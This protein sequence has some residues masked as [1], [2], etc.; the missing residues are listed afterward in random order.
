MKNLFQFVSAVF[1]GK[2]ARIFVVTNLLLLLIFTNWHEVS[3][4][5]SH[6]NQIGCRPTASGIDFSSYGLSGGSGEA[7][8]YTFYAVLFLPSVIDTETILSLLKGV[9]PAWCR[10]TFDILY[11][12]IFTVFN[13]FHWLLLG[14]MIEILHT[15]FL[16][17]RSP[18]INPLGLASKD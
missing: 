6:I 16:L 4:Y 3:Y 15:K 13:S 17:N 2:L 10:E 8:F 5:W 1:K 7:F 11:M 14:F 12:P 18:A 9:F